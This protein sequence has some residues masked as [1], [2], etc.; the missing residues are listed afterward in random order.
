M[1][2]LLGNTEIKYWNMWG[3]FLNCPV[4]HD[5]QQLAFP[6]ALKFSFSPDLKLESYLSLIVQSLIILSDGAKSLYYR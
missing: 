5:F 2:I 4:G 3:F 6:R 1:Q